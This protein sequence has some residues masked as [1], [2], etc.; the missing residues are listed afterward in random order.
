MKLRK[1]RNPR[2]QTALNL[3]KTNNNILKK[4]V[5]HNFNN[6]V[7]LAAI[8][9]DLQTLTNNT[10]IRNERLTDAYLKLSA[11]YWDMLNRLEARESRLDLVT[12][13]LKNYVPDHF[14]FEEDSTDDAE[15]NNNEPEPESL[16]TDKHQTEFDFGSEFKT[17]H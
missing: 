7:D 3:A 14:L 2:Y 5:D 13:Q 8:K 17:K 4:Q 11:R 10:V 15:D 12:Q 16:R 6:I 1:N 9:V